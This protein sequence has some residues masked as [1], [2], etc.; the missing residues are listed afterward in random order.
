MPYIRS[1]TVDG[2]STVSEV[3]ANGGLDDV[4][5]ILLQ[6]I[7][8]EQSPVYLPFSLKKKH[9]E[10][11]ASLLLLL[12]YREVSPPSFRA[13]YLMQPMAS[14]THSRASTHC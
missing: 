12:D 3:E 6:V 10:R 8:S 5:L 11:T 2:C 14:L 9:G 1:P 4:N 7:S 13:L